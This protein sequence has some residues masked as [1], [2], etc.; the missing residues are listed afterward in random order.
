MFA[1]ATVYGRFYTS[2]SQGKPNPVWKTD[3]M[4]Y[5]GLLNGEM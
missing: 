3:T 2:I 5:E 1:R 4:E